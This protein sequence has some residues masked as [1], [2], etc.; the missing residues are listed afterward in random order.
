MTKCK[1]IQLVIEVR[2]ED[3]YSVRRVR[4]HTWSTQNSQSMDNP[5]RLSPCHFSQ[6]RRLLNAEAQL[7]GRE[8]MR[9]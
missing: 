5:H 3:V 7:V 1:M 6:M 9:F 2:I 8:F 4:W